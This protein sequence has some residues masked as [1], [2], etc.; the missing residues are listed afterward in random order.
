[1]KK[2]YT[3]YFLVFF[4]L[5][6]TVKIS[7]QVDR[8]FWFAI[9]KETDGHIY[10]TLNA[11]NTASLRIAAMSQDAEVTIMLPAKGLNL[12]PIPLI[13]PKY[14]TVTFPLVTSNTPATAWE[15]FDSVYSNPAQFD[16]GPARGISNHGIY[17]HSNNDI[18]VYYDY[19]NFWNRDLFS[20]KGKNALGTEF[21]VPFQTIW[22][23]VNVTVGLAPL[24]SPG[25]QQYSYRGAATTKALDAYSDFDVVATENNTSVTILNATGAF[26]TSVTLNAG[27]TYTYVTLPLSRAAAARPAGFHVV[28]DKPVAVTTNDDSVNP[29]SY[30]CDDII[31][32]Q[33]VPSNTTSGTPII[34]T[35]YLVMC[36]DD[37]NT[38]PTAGVQNI[39]RDEQIFVVAT[40]AGTTVTFKDTAGV[41][42]YTSNLNAGGTDYISPEI[43]KGSQ[44]TIS[45]VSSPG[46]P[47]Y[48]L[49]V[50]G[51]TCE[52][53]GAI[54]PP[55]TNCTGSNDVTVVPGVTGAANGSDTKITIELMIPYD[56]A[57]SFSD[58]L[59]QSHYYFTLYSSK[60]AGGQMHIPGK[61]FEPNRVAGWAVLKMA[62]RSWGPGGQNIMTINGANRV[63]NDKDFFHMGMMN[64]TGFYT[65]KY[66]YFSSFNVV[67]PGVRI[68][69]SETQDF[70]GCLGSK[71]ALVASGGMAYSWHYGSTKGAP[72]YLDN[73]TSPTPQA[74]GLPVGS[75]NFYCW[76]INPKCFGTDT[77]KVN[78]VIL[79]SVTALFQ[80]DKSTIC[81]ID[82]IHFTNLSKQAQ[83]YTWEQSIDGG[84]YALLSPVN[85]L[86]FSKTLTNPSNA[87]HYY[88][89]HLTALNNQGCNDTISRTVTVY[90]EIYA[91]FTPRDTSG[92]NPFKL[93]FS[94]ANSSGN[95][96]QY[97]WDFGDQ[98]SSDQVN[99]QHLFQNHILHD[100]TYTAQLVVKSPPPFF[101]TDTTTQDITVHPYI[102]A[103]FSVDTITGCSPFT[104]RIRNVSVGAISDYSW[105]FGDG[106]PVRTDNKDTL[107]HTYPVNTSTNPIKYKLKLTVKNASPTGCP[108]DTSR[109][110]TVNPATSVTF[111]ASAHSVC[112]SASAVQFTSTPSAA[113]TSYH[114]DFGDGS[115]SND[116]NPLH[117]FHNA[118]L[119]DTTYLVQLEVRSNQYCNGYTSDNIIVHAFIDPQFTINTA[120][121]CT[122][123]DV[124]INNASRGGI[125]SYDWSYG[126]GTSDHHTVADTVHTFTSPASNVKETRTITLRVYN[127]GNCTRFQTKTI[128]VNPH[129]MAHFTTI[130]SPPTVCN[131]RQITFNNTSNV[132]ATTFQ[133]DFGD[134][135][136][137]DSVSPHHLYAHMEPNDK[138]YT[139]R[140]I[141]SSAENCKDT[142]SVG[143]GVH[144]YIKADFTVDPAEG[145][146]GTTVTITNKK[147]PGITNYSWN[148]GAGMGADNSTDSIIQKVYTNNNASP[149]DKT[150]TISLTVTNGS[151]N[152]TLT[153][154]V[155]IHPK[156]IPNFTTDKTEGCN[157]LSVRFTDQTLPFGVATDY[158]WAFGD[159]AMSSLKNNTHTFENLGNT[160]KTFKIIL[161]AKSKYN[162]FDTVSRVITVYP[163]I[164][165]DFAFIEYEGCSP[166]Q[167]NIRNASPQ[168]PLY[169]FNFI[170][171]DGS[172]QISPSAINFPYTYRNQSS[173]PITYHPQLVMSYFNGS[174]NLCSQTAT[175][176]VVVYPEVTASFDQD[177]L[178]ACHPYSIQ[179]INN[180]HIGAAFTP[181]N[182]AYQWIF[183]DLGTSGQ[184]NPLHPYTN[185]SNNDANYTVQLTVHSTDGGCT[186]STSKQV[187]IY[188]K[189]KATF[190]AD[191]TLGCA[192]LDVSIDNMSEVSGTYYWDFGDNTKD[193]TQALGTLDHTYDNLTLNTAIYPLSLVV[194]TPY[195]CTDNISQNITVPPRT[196]AGFTPD[197]VG[198][199]PLLVQFK[200]KTILGTN[201]EWDFGDGVFSRTQQP[202]H[203]YFNPGINDTVYT[204]T[205]ISLSH[206]GCSDTS[207]RHITVY[208]QPNANFTALPTPLYYPDNRIDIKNETNAGIWNYFWSFDDGQ[209]STQQEPLYHEYGTWGQYYVRL[210]VW[211]THCTDSV[212]VHISVIPPVPVPDFD[213]TPS[214]CVPL[215]VQFTD[216]STWAT[217]WNWK[218]DDGTFATEQNPTHVYETP[219]KY[220][221]TLTISGDGGTTFTNRTIDVYPKP[222]VNFESDRNLVMLNDAKIIF[223]NKTINGDRYKWDFGDTTT[224][225]VSDPSHTY[226]ALG[227]YTVS[228]HVWTVHNCQDSMIRPDYITVIGKGKLEFP[229]AFKPDLSGPNNGEY[230]DIT[231]NVFHPYAD[232]I[233]EY[234]LE[235]YDRWGEK[236]FSTIDQN[237]GWNGYYRGKLCKADVYVWKCKGKFTNGKTFDKAGNV[238]LM[239]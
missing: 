40:V 54:L 128:P 16:V 143:V 107:Y 46:K 61:W 90:P 83:V 44:S 93:N 195:N 160:L 76:V 60:L 180:S 88:K 191:P 170:P 222:I 3:R 28:A 137:S 47:I 194:I 94:S 9:P 21:Y 233:V 174:T 162:C 10:T 130:P 73:P 225:T 117:Q 58:S 25:F 136:S 181:A 114:W 6:V 29:T 159:G 151:C 119:H 141:A 49:H 75:H 99:P 118:V 207:Q 145:C 100:T 13:V 148:Y 228:L 133:W 196:S 237:K 27:Q 176:D 14:T 227:T 212:K 70:I 30:G 87:A 190:F 67:S 50:S 216:R 204:V 211:N 74:L 161:T 147:L 92:C 123:F 157:P 51:H 86:S 140:L 198:C 101:C 39:R 178:K 144:S 112:D 62:Y 11:T 219:G 64:G 115:T 72:L 169:N 69:S 175:H 172:P 12:T 42:L 139:A 103:E 84:S 79:P 65:N 164:E 208:P 81:A 199:S 167:I 77:L 185:F 41:I 98:G 142:F 108:D 124:K 89:Y 177:T 163:F 168:G 33:L 111:T 229:N 18:T 202:T 106:T 235:V 97:I 20:L 186:N 45:V 48:V 153:R 80:I 209:T 197:T 129:V 56:P 7:A 68:S 5:S 91:D 82:S 221:V 236:L 224:S 152:N 35:Q 110:I 66:G 173:A 232:G 184:K 131:P 146:D 2:L 126:D 63:V 138:F 34:G 78:V 4:L 109:W 19:D 166:H 192:P 223:H 24:G 102:H 171:G 226:Q 122:P 59:H 23:N 193:T 105:D 200:N 150:Y 206:Y 231:D 22:N 36:G 17:I 26:V 71:P 215:T 234:K 52:V 125:T 155:V 165:P 116:A 158:N 96:D 85:P 15:Q 134:G 187:I 121:H 149:L 132:V 32:D 53:G 31:G 230:T 217:S 156:V 113:V 43:P 205:M 239:R 189:P 188:P 37:A 213:M 57:Y 218:F 104:V 95:L 182:L 214:G 55:I 238:T 8:D 183:G 220:V 120:T 135:V 201:F 154:T 127:S 210:H 1:M 179:F 38:N 203:K